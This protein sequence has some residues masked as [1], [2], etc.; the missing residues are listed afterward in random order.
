M[1][2]KTTAC[3]S[4]TSHPVSTWSGRVCLLHVFHEHL[5]CD[6]SCPLSPVRLAWCFYPSHGLRQGLH[7]SSCDGDVASRGSSDIKWVTSITGEQRDSVVHLSSWIKGI[8]YAKWK[9]GKTDRCWEKIR[10]SAAS[11]QS[12]QG[13]W[14]RSI[15]YSLKNALGCSLQDELSHCEWN[16]LY[17]W[18]TVYRFRIFK[19]QNCCL[20]ALIISFF[21]RMHCCW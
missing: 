14:K 17:C 1:T 5:T 18:M 19:W 6:F 11:G 3:D 7:T 9:C 16:I 20:S 21:C 13:W 10:A 12:E 15:L 4:S 2:D 8:S